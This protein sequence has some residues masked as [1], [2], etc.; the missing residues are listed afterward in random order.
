MQAILDGLAHV[1]SLVSEIL[2]IAQNG[3]VQRYVA[4]FYCGVIVLALYGIYYAVRVLGIL[5]GAF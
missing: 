3:Q 5:G 1:V 4:V 2:S